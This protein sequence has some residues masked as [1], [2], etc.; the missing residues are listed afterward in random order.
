MKSVT[1]VIRP[2]VANKA[3]WYPERPPSSEWREV[4]NAVLQRDG[5][6]CRGCGHRAFTRMMIHHIKPGSD[7]GIRNL[8]TLCVA[9][10][11]VLHV[12]MSLQYR[13]VEIWESAID[14]VAIIRATR[15]GVRRGKSLADV[16]ASLALRRGPLP[17]SSVEYANQLLRDMGDAP[18]S[19][20]PEPLCAV[21][22]KF[23]TWQLQ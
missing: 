3:L 17:P 22:V 10:H 13:A 12:G 18:W 9:C 14:Q 2:G 21:F 7:D 23:K 1:L 20:L 16:K 6:T 11:A 8:V 5:F 19:A 4:R 15:E